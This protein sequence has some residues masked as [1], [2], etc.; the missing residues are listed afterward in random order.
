MEEFGSIVKK[1]FLFVFGPDG[2]SNHFYQ[3]LINAEDDSIETG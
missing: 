1:R 2:S 3:V